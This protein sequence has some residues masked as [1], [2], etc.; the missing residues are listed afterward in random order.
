M[1]SG[2]RSHLCA[3]SHSV[4]M[5]YPGLAMFDIV[6]TLGADSMFGETVRRLRAL[7]RLPTSLVLP[8]GWGTEL[9]GLPKELA[10]L[11]NL[12]PGETTATGN[13]Y[14]TLATVVALCL[15]CEEASENILM[16]FA[17]LRA[18]DAR[19]QQLLNV[20][21]LPALVLMAWWYAR[22]VKF[23]SEEILRRARVE[24]QDICVYVESW[25]H[26][27]SDIMTA[28]EYPKKVLG[29]NQDFIDNM[30]R[31]PAKISLKPSLCQHPHGFKKTD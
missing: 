11:L 9:D 21:D 6:H 28:L 29:V 14:H 10:A 24:G 17:F 8:E 22:L 31:K 25:G 2:P 27:S 23:D 3:T 12:N 20:K 18:M 26:M 30:R 16:C 15:E 4:H 19:F 1:R 13:T 7:R 5:T